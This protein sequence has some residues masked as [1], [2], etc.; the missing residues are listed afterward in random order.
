[1]AGRTYRYF[2]GEALYPFGHGLSYTSFAY[3]NLQVRRGDAGVLTVTVD[4]TNTG[5]RDGDEVVQLYATPP[6]GTRPREHRALCG[7]DRVH[8][9]AG[10]TRAVSLT[11]PRSALRRWSTEQ[12]AYVIPSGQW[13]IG[14]GASSSDIRQH[15]AVTLE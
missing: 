15:A 1:M 13:T 2:G 8:L 9:K 12:K 10:E 11:V 6:P 7:F 3:A 14:A 4:V 5:T